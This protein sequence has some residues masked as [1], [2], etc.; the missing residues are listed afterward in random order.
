MEIS[1]AA[2]RWI[3]EQV[4]ES[5]FKYISDNTSKLVNEMLTNQNL[6]K[7]IYYLDNE[8]IH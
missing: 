5:K 4:R 3:Y 6:A 7:Y 1:A 2:F 8:N